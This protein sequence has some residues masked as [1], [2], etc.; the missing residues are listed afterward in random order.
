MPSITTEELYWKNLPDDAP[1]SVLHDF[2]AKFPEGIFA[3]L[4]RA[5]ANKQIGRVTEA[6]LEEFLRYHPKTK[7]RQEV[8]ARL[9]VLKRDRIQKSTDVA[10]LERIIAE[11][12]S[13]ELA[14]EV[15]Q[16][17]DSIRREAEES[18][19]WER[20]KVSSNAGE[21]EQFLKNYPD[22]KF[23]KLARE[24]LEELTARLDTSQKSTHVNWLRYAAVAALLVAVG[25]GA[26]FSMER[27]SADRS[28]T[29][30]AELVAAGDDP[31]RLRTFIS[32]CE[33]ASC[34]FSREAKDRLAKVE[35]ARSRQ[36]A[37]TQRRALAAVPNDVAGLSAFVDKCRRESCL[38]LDDAN[39]RLAAAQATV[40][41]AEATRQRKEAD[42][43]ALAAVP[44]D[45]ASLSAFVD[46]CKKDSCLM[47]EEASSRLAVVQAEADRHAKAASLGFNTFFN[48][49]IDKNDIDDGKIFNTNAPSCSEK[50]QSINECVAFVFDKWN[51]ACYL[52]NQVGLLTQTPRSNTF[53]RTDMRAIVATTK[54]RSCP[55]NDS[56]MHGDVSKSLSAPST[57]A[58]KQKC[59]A[60]TGCIA[61]TFRK[62]DR[63]CTFF[64]SVS[65]RTR[66]DP[67]S[68]S[69]E[70]T[71]N[72][73]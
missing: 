63:Q 69:G 17:I 50:C 67:T 4:A 59:E 49:D 35:Q 41:A 23:S 1:L 48:Y 5:L 46:K 25:A 57:D 70:R 43:K 37:E 36:V 47:S 28:E 12:P 52:K 44:N 71:Q 27:K 29:L 15:K 68:N 64:S 30:R 3:P 53:V 11:D 18:E 14:G 21:L 60:E 6:E 39:G 40:R 7:F 55:Y 38:V 51:S 16:R 34:P 54:P 2:L 31:V 8:A 33:T 45:V 61:Y 72:P 65:D 62:A 9:V 22:G 20:V 42:S 26:L 19:A 32:Q 73:C 56:S 10:A 66:N 58:C 13:N 24:R